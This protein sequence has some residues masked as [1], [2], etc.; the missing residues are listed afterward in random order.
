MASIVTTDCL[1]T[2]APLTGEVIATIG[3]V[4]SPDPDGVAVVGTGVEVGVGAMVGEEVGGDVGVA[5]GTTVGVC[6]GATIG[7]EVGDD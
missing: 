1:G 2:L 6:V 7:D 4:T 3:A 5:V